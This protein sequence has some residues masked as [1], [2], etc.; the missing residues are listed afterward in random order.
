M[1]PKII[2][3]FLLLFSQQCIAQ[4]TPKNKQELRKEVAQLINE[5]RIS[6]NLNPL[7][8]DATLLKAAENHSLYLS[9]TKK[10]SHWQIDRDLA[11]PIKRVKYFGG[12]DWHV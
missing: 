12:N 7:E 2:F 5:L 4:F 1:A 8:F 6:K 3:L 11:Y 10:L 9:E